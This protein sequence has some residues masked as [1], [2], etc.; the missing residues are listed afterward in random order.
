[1]KRIIALTGATLLVLA[2]SSAFAQRSTEMYIPIGKSPGISGKQTTIGTIS[3]VK[4]QDRVIACSNASGSMW[5]KISAKTRIWLDRSKAKLPNTPGT[6]A[7]CAKGR[8]IEVKYVTND[9]RDGG[10]ADWVKVEVSTP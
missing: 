8:T 2:S 1:M 4:Q 7:D 3:D 6:F 9:R 5:A 10:E